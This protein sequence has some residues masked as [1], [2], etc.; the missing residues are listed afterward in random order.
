MPF[1]IASAIAL[2]RRTVNTTLA[3]QAFYMDASM[4][5][6]VETRARLH[7]RIDR[8]GDLE[9][10]GYAEVV[11]GVDR[12]VLIPQDVNG[13]PLVLR[14]NGTMTF[15]QIGG[16]DIKVVLRVREP[17]DGPLNETWQVSRL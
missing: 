5:A 4:S 14:E 11:E 6:P 10:Q 8:F 12:I 3:V 13:N 9:N 17:A 1:D 16:P 7:S 2:A 15:P